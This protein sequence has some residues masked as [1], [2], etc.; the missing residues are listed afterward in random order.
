MASSTIVEK[1]CYF[2][3]NVSCYEVA[4]DFASPLL[5]AIA[6]VASV[7]IAF[8]QL[9]KQH[10]NTLDAQK[11]EAKRN[12]RVELFKDINVLLDQSTVSIRQVNS[13]CFGK[14]YSNLEMK[15]QIDHV[16]YFELMQNFGNALLAVISKVESH[17]IVNLKLF[18]VFRFALQSIHHDLLALQ[19]E[20]ERFKVLET[21]IELT[22][23]SIMYFGDFQVCMQNM[24]YGEVFNSDVPHRVPADKR[25]KV[26][27]N[28]PVSLDKLHD[29]F[30]RE[31][32]WGKNCIKYENEAKEKFSS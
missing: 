21:I 9:S 14:K 7:L 12:T 26:I 24:A 11:E 6:V 2:I 20:K 25:Y 27:T 28:C 31:T 23:D 29:Y 32:N 3:S 19:T 1:S 16:E 17:E 8:K 4:K 13:Y 5:A 10:Q 30:W 15:A 18:R 22:N